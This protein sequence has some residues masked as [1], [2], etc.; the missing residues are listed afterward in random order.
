[1]T[2]NNSITT[3][4]MIVTAIIAVVMNG[5]FTGQ[6]G[7]RNQISAIDN[8]LSLYPNIETM[9]V[10]LSGVALPK[11]ARLM[12]RHSGETAWQEG[13]PLFR[14][15]DGRLV[16]SLFGLSPVSSYD[17]KVLNGSTEIS[18]SAA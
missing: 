17:I 14:I 10:V 4:L 1:M 16:G 9:G 13:H 11:T 2:N 15:D 5:F 18:G 3:P 6:L 12:Y 8:Q 7:N